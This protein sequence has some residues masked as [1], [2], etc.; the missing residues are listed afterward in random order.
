MTYLLVTGVA[1][2]H[3]GEQS[4]VFEGR[5]QAMSELADL[6][7]ASMYYQLDGSLPTFRMVADVPCSISLA[8][9]SEVTVRGW[10]VV[11]L[12]WP[13]NQS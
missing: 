8:A 1:P 2:E 4:S 13:A 12:T 5:L 9:M 7:P 6:L 11:G 10:T 3:G